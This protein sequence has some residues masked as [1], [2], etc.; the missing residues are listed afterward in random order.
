MPLAK[1]KDL[2]I[3]EYSASMPYDQFI[4]ELSAKHPNKVVVI[5]GHS[6]TIPEILKVL[7]K[8]SFSISIEDGE[9]DNLFVVTCSTEPN[10][11]IIHLKYGNQLQTQSSN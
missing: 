3:I 10:P 8:G 1:A 5:A 4:D 7:S 11:S 2:P 9:Y 6:N